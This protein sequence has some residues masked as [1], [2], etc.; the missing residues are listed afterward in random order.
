MLL[1]AGA[2]MGMVSVDGTCTLGVLVDQAL[3]LDLLGTTPSERS[4][5]YLLLRQCELLPFSNCNLQTHRMAQHMAVVEAGDVSMDVGFLG[6]TC[7]PP[8]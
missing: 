8:E 6:H 5:L 2:G 7:A 4:G 3:I 1:Q